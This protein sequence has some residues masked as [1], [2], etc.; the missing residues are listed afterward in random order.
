[1]SPIAWRTHGRSLRVGAILMLGSLLSACQ[2]TPARAPIA[3]VPQ[4]D[5]NRYMGQW[6]V[7]AHIPAFIE[8]GAF[9]AVESY[10]LTPDGEIATTFTFRQGSFAGPEKTYHPTG[11]V[12]D[13]ASNA[14]WDMQFVWPVKAE[15][16][17]AAVNKDYT[18]TIVA[19]SKRDYVW[20]MARTPQISD[21]DYEAL[22]QQVRSYG[23]DM[24][25]LRRVPQQWP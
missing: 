9:N 23:Y 17:V 13:T 20:I 3:P 8:K 24:T 6:Y 21:K 5:L 14:V 10:Q 4:V 25:R 19:R 18:Q 11:F 2:S 12:R 1:M 22:F 16:L 7:I 15:Y